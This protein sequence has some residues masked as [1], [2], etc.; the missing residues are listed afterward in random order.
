MIRKLTGLSLI[1]MCLFGVVFINA[2]AQ[3]YEY[4]EPNEAELQYGISY[5]Q[6]SGSWSGCSACHQITSYSWLKLITDEEIYSNYDSDFF[7]DHQLIVIKSGT[8]SPDCGLR[9]TE[10]AESERYTDIILKSITNTAEE[11]RKWTIVLEFEKTSAKYISL[12]SFEG[13]CGANDSADVKWT[14]DDEG[15]LTI[16]G[17]GAMQ[18]YYPDGD[19]EPGF[20]DRP[21]NSRYVKRAVIE[22]GVTNIGAAA[23]SGC[24]DM[25]NITIADSV[26]SI[27]D[28]SFQSCRSLAGVKLPEEVTLI[29]DCAFYLCDNLAEISLP[30]ALKR[31]GHSAFNC[32]LSLNNI[33]IPS[34]VEFIGNRAFAYCINLPSIDVDENNG[35]YISLDGVLFNKDKT[36]LMVY[37]SSKTDTEYVIPDT[38]EKIADTAFMYANFQSVEIPDSVKSI[39]H[40]SFYRC[41]NLISL[42]LPASVEKLSNLSFNNCTYL[43]EINVDTEN[44]NYVSMDGV[45]F[46]KD[47]TTLMLYPQSKPDVHYNIPEGVTRLLPYSFHGNLELQSISIAPSITEINGFTFYLCQSLRSVILPHT[48]E[49]IDYAAF[50]DCNVQNVYITGPDLKWIKL[51]TYLHTNKRFGDDAQISVYSTMIKDTSQVVETNGEYVFIIDY[52]G[53]PLYSDV[54]TVLY[55]DNA[56]TGIKTTKITDVS[57]ENIE[58]GR[59]VTKVSTEN[60]DAAKVFIWNNLCNMEPIWTSGEITQFN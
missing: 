54:I 50:K 38:V 52:Q 17:T 1:L 10:V 3:Q 30:D 56:M 9:V 32:C 36:E 47:K 5:Y 39:G 42:N 43:Q 37:P 33:A 19:P 22:D 44:K 45:L 53:V 29:G 59:L 16:K 24:E 48:L 23:F 26:T 46:D 57:S 6:G 12:V 41:E 2:S 14:L 28:Y 25:E 31:I 18:D 49:Y 51:L 4:S 27:G 35:N 11:E 55:K 21:W 15:T 20:I 13:I 34:G 8:L 7:N 58:N 60:A 40:S